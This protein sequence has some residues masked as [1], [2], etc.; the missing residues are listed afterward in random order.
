MSPTGWLLGGVAAALVSILPVPAT[1]LD[2]PE[3]QAA[4]DR[5]LSLAA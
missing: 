5:L 1:T 4:V 3:I 2:E